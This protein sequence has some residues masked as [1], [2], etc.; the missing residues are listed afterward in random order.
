MNCG[1]GLLD[2][3]L[4]GGS[5]FQTL[6]KLRQGLMALRRPP[7]RLQ[8]GGKKVGDF[9][10]RGIGATGAGGRSERSDSAEIERLAGDES[11]AI[12]GNDH[13]PETRTLLQVNIEEPVAADE[14]FT[15]LMGDKVEPRER[16][17]P[18]QCFGH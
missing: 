7:Y 12:V 9:K 8:D 1:H 16:F 13:G 3:E 6:V 4:L 17:Y 2:W 11:R 10:P 5:D 15:I 18:E 14:I